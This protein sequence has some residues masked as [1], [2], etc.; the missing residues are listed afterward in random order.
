MIHG[1]QVVEVDQ[2]PVPYVKKGTGAPVIMTHLPTSPFH[3]FERNQEELSKH[4]CVYLIDL[5]PAVVLKTWLMRGI[6]LLEYLREVI[7]GFM[8]ALGLERVHLIGAHKAGA[9]SMYVAAKHPDRVDRLVLY[10]TLGI[11]KAPSQAPVFKIIFLCMNLPFVPFMA[12]L[13]WLRTLVKWLDLAGTGQW[14]VGQFFGPDEPHDYHSLTRH[15]VEVYSALLDPPDVFGYEVMVWTIR[16]LDYGPVV[17]LIS[18]IKRPALLV[19]G[20]D[21]YSIPKAHIEEYRRLLSGAEILTF[22][23]TRIYPN[24]ERHEVVNRKTLE[25]LGG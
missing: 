13:R 24:Y 4:F 3:C 6:P 9:V 23:N 25:F 21:E 1:R 15:L 20:E 11:T 2:V 8:D 16:M 12:R 10:S 7:I 14:R 19:F 18:S 22:P 17:P 5:R